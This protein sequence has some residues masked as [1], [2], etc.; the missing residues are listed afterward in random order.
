MAVTSMVVW[1]INPGRGGEFLQQCAQAKAIHER[2]GS[3]VRLVQILFGGPM[4]GN[5]AYVNEFDDWTGFAA[6]SDQMG[7][8]A[9]WLQ[10]WAS[11]QVNPSARLVSRTL[12]TT[13][14]GF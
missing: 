5:V 1:E 8:D 12:G 4:S 13:V 7:T 10:F 14:P 11:A 9:E 2:L 3:R 6:F